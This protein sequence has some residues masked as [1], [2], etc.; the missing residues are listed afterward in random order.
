VCGLVLGYDQN[1]LLDS[2]WIKLQNGLSYYR[3]PFHCPTSFE[4]Q[5]LDCKV[6]YTDANQGIMPESH[7]IWVQYT[8]SD[9]D[10]TIQGRVPS[11]PV[12]DFWWIPPNQI[13]QCHERLPAGKAISTFSTRCKKA[14]QWI[15]HPQDQ[16]YAL[17]IP[18]K[19]KDQ[20]G[21]A[22]C[23]DMFIRVVKQSYL[24]HI[25]PCRSNCWTGTFDARECCIR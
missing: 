9:L 10:N 3:Q 11:F 23:V 8:E 21:W 1:V 6:E 5:G 18:T 2:I 7:N 12:L 25:V 17:V 22:D 4:H 19:S 14:Q 16:E 20:H 13:L 24:M 15:L